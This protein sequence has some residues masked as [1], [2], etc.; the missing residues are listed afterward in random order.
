M[1][2]LKVLAS[3][4]F[5][6][7]PQTPTLLDLLGWHTIQTVR[8]K[9][10]DPTDLELTNYLRELMR[11]L[12]L[13][14]NSPSSIFFPGDQIM[15][16]VW[17]ELILETANYRT[18]CNKFKSG[19]FLDHNSITFDEY[20]SL[21]GN[22][23][24]HSE[25][26]S[27]LASYLLNFGPIEPSAFK[28]LNLAKTLANKM[29]ANLD[30]LNAFGQ[31]IVESQPKLVPHPFSFDRYVEE[32]VG[33]NANQIDKDPG[34]LGQCIKEIILGLQQT[35]PN[36]LVLLTLEQLEKLFSKSTALAFTLWQHLGATEK[37][38]EV[39]EWQQR[40]PDLWRKIA[41][42]ETLC[43]LATTNLGKPGGAG[44]RGQESEDGF[45]LNG[46]APWV[47]GNG[48]FSHLVVGFETDDS[49]V[50]SVIDAPVGSTI[51][52]MK[53]TEAVLHSLS[54][55]NGSATYQ[56][57]FA[58][59]Q[60]SKSTVVN[61]KFKSGSPQIRPSRYVI[62]ELGI[63]MGVIE[64]IDRISNI[65]NHPKQVFVKE[66]LAKLVDRLIAIRK[67]RKSGESL[68]VLIPIR[69]ELIRDSIRLLCLATGA[70]AL[71]K[72]SLVSRLQLELILLDSV[73]Q[74]PTV[75]SKK[76]RSLAEERHV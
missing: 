51:T 61:R 15:D 44:I 65:S 42:G 39:E 1:D 67:M 28:I 63:A 27:W 26:C 18:L 29:N 47:C 24:V 37:L 55:L 7:G 9:I 50:F 75:I 49:V 4:P 46:V 62:P 38:S 20:V 23:A 57:K 71:T 21:Q 74:M 40:N 19:R 45:I 17:H 66:S 30:Q 59:Q 3:S 32:F 76:I 43:G 60:I 35:E 53:N 72:D 34:L 33:A 10:S 2:D 13:A 64:E 48:I 6:L 8:K 54:C 68:D 36:S 70:G 5:K 14:A 52:A 25:Q 31:F 69:D 41:S 22:E 11:F 56:L 12:Y 58:N 73:V 16:N